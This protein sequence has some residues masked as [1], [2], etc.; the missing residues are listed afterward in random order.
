ML[1]T[2]SHEDLR[3]ALTAA[4]EKLKEHI[5]TNMSERAAAALKEEMETSRAA[6]PR[7]A[8][9]AQQRV[10]AVA[11]QLAHEGGLTLKPAGENGEPGETGSEEDREQ[12]AS[13]PQEE[14]DPEERPEADPEERPEAETRG[15][16]G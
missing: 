14:A 2:V 5:L 3:F 1:R 11:R 4:G 12:Q 6:N 8:R 10:A 15:E 13:A 7:Q 9:A 16:E